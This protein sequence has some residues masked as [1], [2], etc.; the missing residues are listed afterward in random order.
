MCRTPIDL[1][2]IDRIAAH[3]ERTP[4]AKLYVEGEQSITTICNVDGPKRKVISGEADYVL[5]YKDAQRDFNICNSF[6]A[7]DAKR[8]GTLDAAL[9]QCSAYM[10]EQLHF[11]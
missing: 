5:G 10:G 1:I 8:A 3:N 6:V 7:I 4:G 11:H 9:P 2:L